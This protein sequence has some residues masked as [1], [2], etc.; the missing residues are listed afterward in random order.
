MKNNL[1]S[2]TVV[3]IIATVIFSCSNDKLGGYT[4]ADN[5]TLFKV[6]YRG[7]D[8]SK[9]TDTEIVIVN[10][11]YRL[12]DTILF[13]SISLGEPMKFPMI[14]PMFK[15]DLYD[16]LTLMGKGDSLTIAV[17]ADSFYIRTA[18]LSEL[19]KFV[20]P[21]SY[22]Y[23]DIKLLNHISQADFQAELDEIRKEDERQEKILL[24]NYL[25]KNNINTTPTTTGLY[26]IP[27]EKGRGRTPDTGDM[28]QI[29]LSVQQLDGTELFT[30]FGERALDVE[31]GKNFDTKGF[32]EGLGL[33]NIGGKARLI[34]PSWIGVGSMGREVV[35][36]YTTLIYEVKLEAIRSLEEVQ[37][38]RAH[39]KKEKE[40]ENQRLKESEPAKI[41]SYIKK[42]NIDVQPLE[43]GLYFKELVAGEGSNPI[44]G[45]TV[46][47]EYIQY[48]LKGNVVQSSYAD[49]TPFTYIVGTSAVI[50]GW[51]ESVKLM[52]KG[53]KAWMLI[54]S[55]IG[56]KD[57]ERTK[58]IKPY[59]PLVFELEVVDIKE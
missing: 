20:E 37:K 21:G 23:Y 10:L 46:T 34:V 32:M 55:K 11:T 27:I 13:S 43:S 39:Y 22:L 26:F 36:P 25:V 6:H 28:C 29:F 52:K 15:G 14:K 54:P 4:T 17:V 18:N 53:G 30:N 51:E 31:Y 47:V 58:G 44:D 41:I 12:D 38:D 9:A 7:S 33:L 40:I 1:I 45:N 35:P 42:N 8:T 16:G 2:I 48:D 5:G 56:W 24:Q 59:S 19:P 3:M 50:D 49:N 57:Q